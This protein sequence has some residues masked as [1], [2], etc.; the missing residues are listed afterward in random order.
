MILIELS[1]VVPAETITAHR[2]AHLD[3]LAAAKAEGRLLV[4]GRKQPV[5]GGI[6]IVSGTLAEAE[7]WAKTDPF[8][9]EGLAEYRFLDIAVSM[10]APGLEALAG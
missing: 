10:T 8:A 5:T 9:I 4:S 1:Y 3:W 7:A 6:L 2:A